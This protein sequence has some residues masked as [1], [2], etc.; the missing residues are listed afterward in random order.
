MK[1]NSA[2]DQVIRSLDSVICVFGYWI[3]TE[4]VFITTGHSQNL[5]KYYLKSA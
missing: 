2:W 3:T 1:V 4:K 5:E